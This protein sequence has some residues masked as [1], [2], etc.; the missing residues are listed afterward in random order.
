MLALL[1]S[2]AVWATTP[3][4]DAQAIEPAD[5][6]LDALARYRRMQILT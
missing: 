3:V 5:F 1:P 6:V 4:D 2:D